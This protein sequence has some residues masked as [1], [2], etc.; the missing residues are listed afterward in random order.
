M[1]EAPTIAPTTGPTLWKPR[2]L[3][4]SNDHSNNQKSKHILCFNPCVEYSNQ[5]KPPTQV[6]IEFTKVEVPL[7]HFQAHTLGSSHTAN[8]SQ[9]GVTRGILGLNLTKH[10]LAQEMEA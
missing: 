5:K 2:G 4:L 3:K 6:V 1:S 10:V 9:V 7:S 8:D